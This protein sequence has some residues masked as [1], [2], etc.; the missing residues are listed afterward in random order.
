MSGETSAG[1][2]RRVDW[3]LRQ[4]VAVL[5]L[6]LGADDALRGHD[7]DR[8]RDNLQAILDSTR[9]AHPDVSIVIAGMAAPLPNLGSDVYRAVSAD[10]SS[11]SPRQRRR[12]DPLP[13]GGRQAAVPELNQPDGIHPTAEGQKILA[14]NVWRT[15]EPVL[16]E[17]TA[18][19]D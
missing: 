11:S 17:R 3:V 8:T 15:L 5:V 7:L 13:P 14:E 18:A 9:A 16:R 10:C 2:L 12:P 19:I 4:P 6:A 1:G